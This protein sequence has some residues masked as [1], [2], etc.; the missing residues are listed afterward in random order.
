MTSQQK[1]HELRAQCKALGLAASG[2]NR[3]LFD[4]L[5]Q[6]EKELKADQ[7]K[8]DKE[9]VDGP[10]EAIVHSSVDVPGMLPDDVPVH[11]RNQVLREIEH[12]TVDYDHDPP[13]MGKLPRP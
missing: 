9:S 7:A 3:E 11:C 13:P 4:R 10:V 2:S 6:R 8:V 1:Q 12:A 5:Q